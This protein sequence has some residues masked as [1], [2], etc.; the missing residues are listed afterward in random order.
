MKINKATYQTIVFLLSLFYVNFFAFSPF[1]HNYH[2]K[3]ELSHTQSAIIYSPLTNDCC[4]VDCDES[5]EGHLEDCSNNSHNLETCYV[6]NSFMTR[7]FQS[8]LKID[9]DSNL[10]YV[11]HYD[12]KAKFKKP[13]QE[14]FLLLLVR[15]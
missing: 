8:D 9:I 4:E 10:R 15:S 7:S 6:N 3:K 12:D 2:P 14:D 1:S 5:N 11:I 13:V